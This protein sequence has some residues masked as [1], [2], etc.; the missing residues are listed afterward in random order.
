[1]SRQPSNLP[2]AESTAGP[3]DASASVSRRS[4][5]LT[6]LVLIAIVTFLVYSPSFHGA[7]L[8]DDNVYIT[9]PEFQSLPG[10]YRIWFELGATQQ[11]YP[12]VHSAFWLEHKLWG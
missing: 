12:L 4:I 10:L 7:M 8:W 5:E 9:R 11:Y 2:R 1:M 3:P 6:A